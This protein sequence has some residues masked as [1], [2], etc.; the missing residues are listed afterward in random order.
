[1]SDVTCSRGGRRTL[2][3]W[4]WVVLFLLYAPIGVLVVFSFND[5]AVPALPLTDATTRWYVDAFS[6]GP[7]LDSIWA[8]VIT[9]TWTAVFSVAIGLSAVLGLQRWGGS[10]GKGALATLFMSPLVMPY[11]VLGVSLLMLLRLLGVERSLATVIL[12]HVVLTLPFVVLILQPRLAQIPAALHEASRDLGASEFITFWKVTAPLMA[13]ATF[14]AL[15][16]AFTVSFD[17]YAV[18][19]FVVGER[20]TFPVYLF[21]QLRFP[22]QLPEVMAVAVAALVASLVI[23]VV[24]ETGRRIAEN[25]ISPELSEK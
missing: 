22:Q 7:L 2:W 16:V 4:F 21:S 5:N 3:S 19:S 12:G 20:P 10:R 24:A 1:M 13:P 8:S 14:S 15:L 17:E 23:L 18:A 11:V 25:R 9:A 6:N